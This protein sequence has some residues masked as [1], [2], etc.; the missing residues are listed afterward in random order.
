[1]QIRLTLLLR[2]TL[3]VQIIQITVILCIAQVNHGKNKKIPSYLCTVRDLPY[4]IKV[5]RITRELSKSQT[6]TRYPYVY[7]FWIWFKRKGYNLLWYFGSAIGVL[8]ARA[9]F[10]VSIV[11]CLTFG[12]INKGHLRQFQRINHQILIGMPLQPTLP[13]TPNRLTYLVPLSFIGW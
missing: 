4:R 7:I 13:C 3:M 8:S 9:L 2:A 5:P 12:L 6:M 1:M 11:L 10:F